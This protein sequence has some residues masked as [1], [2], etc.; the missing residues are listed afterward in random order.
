VEDKK[1]MAE[2]LINYL[3]PIHEKRRQ[4]LQNPHLLEEVIEDG[5]RRAGEVARQTMEEVRQAMKI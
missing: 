1:I 3:A 5:C 4:I 2:N